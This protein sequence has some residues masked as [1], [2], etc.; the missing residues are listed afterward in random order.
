MT[1]G[2]IQA[3]LLKRM[4]QLR[5]CQRKNNT[6]RGKS[7]CI[8]PDFETKQ[9]MKEE[10]GNEFSEAEARLHRTVGL[11]KDTAFDFINFTEFLLLF[12]LYGC[13]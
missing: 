1:H 13:E 6:G 12:L 8:C 4:N 2:A 10:G 7:K 5:E 11:G 3:E 9:V